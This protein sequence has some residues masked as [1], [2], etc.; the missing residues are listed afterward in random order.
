VI[1]LVIRYFRNKQTADLVIAQ[2]YSERRLDGGLTD[3]KL[4]TNVANDGKIKDLDSNDV[5]AQK[6]QG[7]V[8]MEVFED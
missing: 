2:K 3:V 5:S 4:K 6:L 8:E 7:N 1:A